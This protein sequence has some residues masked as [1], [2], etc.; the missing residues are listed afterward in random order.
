MKTLAIV[1]HL[2]TLIGDTDGVTGLRV[3]R[4][5]GIRRIASGSKE[6]TR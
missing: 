1:N 5:G 2:A 4:A 3:I 6:K